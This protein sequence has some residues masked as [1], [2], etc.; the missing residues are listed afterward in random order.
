[1]FI[2]HM[3]NGTLLYR[4]SYNKGYVIGPSSVLYINSASVESILDQSLALLIYVSVLSYSIPSSGRV[5]YHNNL[6]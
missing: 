5:C 4:A 6:Y 2:L 3:H 1:M